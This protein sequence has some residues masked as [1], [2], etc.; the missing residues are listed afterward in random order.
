VQV[1]V[2]FLMNGLLVVNKPSGKSS[3]GVVYAVRKLTGEKRV[4][5]AGTLDPLATGVLVVCLGQAV[6]VSEYLISH[7]KKYRARVRLGVE[8]DT[9]DAMGEIVARREVDVAPSDIATALQSFIGKIAQIPPAHSAIQRDGVRAYTL[10]RQGVAVELAPREVEV[11]AVEL[12]RIEND[13]VEFDV[14]CSKGTYIRSLAHDLGAQLGT[15]AHLSALTRLVS[16]PFTLEQSLTLEEIERAVAQGTLAQYLLPLDLALREFDAVNLDSTE[17]RAIQQGRFIPA[18]G[19]LTPL[20]RAYDEA[21]KLIALLER[22]DSLLK[23][24]KVFES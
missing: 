22:A 1:L 4:G 6:R 3:H 18:R 7:D 10:A 11:Y 19:D 13:E 2:Y 24:R 21:G 5:H 8:T 16:G 23:P 12:R 20:V 15:G 9:Y 17:A 14:Y